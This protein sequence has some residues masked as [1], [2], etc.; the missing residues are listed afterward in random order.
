MRGWRHV[1]P[2][3]AGC[4]TEAAGTPTGAAAVYAPN[5]WRGDVMIVLSLT[6]NFIYRQPWGSQALGSHNWDASQVSNITI[7]LGRPGIDAVITAGNDPS[8]GT[9]LAAWVRRGNDPG[10]RQLNAWPD[11]PAIVAMADNVLGA[12][13]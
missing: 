12:W 2:A 4:V 5:V 13:R 6:E 8:N 7:Y 1:G 10:S 9:T 3:D 11:V